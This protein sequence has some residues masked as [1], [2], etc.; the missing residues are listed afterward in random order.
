MNIERKGAMLSK[1]YSKHKK[2]HT[3]WKGL[4]DFG[5][6]NNEKYQWTRENALFE[7]S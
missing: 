3:Y 6:F 5:I 4:V 1:L 2:V 7:I